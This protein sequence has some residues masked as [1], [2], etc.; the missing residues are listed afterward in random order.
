MTNR[1]KY[2]KEILDLS[3]SG[4]SFAKVDGKITKCSETD[5]VECDFGGSYKCRMKIAEWANSEYDD[6]PV[7][8]SKVAVDT[9]IFVKDRESDKWHPRHFAKYE[10]GMVYTWDSGATSWSASGYMS[11]W[12]YAKLTESVE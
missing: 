11:K 9:K 3:C 8:W 12:K 7:D 6:L 1:E 4:Y 5:C 10:N 2:A